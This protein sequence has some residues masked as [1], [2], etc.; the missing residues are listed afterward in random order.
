MEFVKR[1]NPDR[2]AEWNYGGAKWRLSRSKIDLFIECPRCFYVDNKLGTKR[3]GMPSFNLNIAVD[4]LFKKEF[5]VHRANGT[6]HPIMQKYKVDAV[7]FKHKQMDEWR[8]PFVGVSHLHEATDLTVCGGVDDLWQAPDG[9]LII[10]DY[11]ATSKVGRIEKLGDSPWE[12]QYQRQLGVYRWLLEKNGFEVEP[13]GYLV[14]ANASKDEDAFDDKLTFE[15]TLVT[16]PTDVEWI[17]PTLESIKKTLESDKIP[18]T[19][20]ACEYCPYREASGKKL[21]K[22]HMDNKKGNLTK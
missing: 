19:G 17:E 16:C 20:P 3:P 9:K 6:P 18:P 5:D 22:M 14:Y 4:E 13:T 1:Y 10:V 7:P 11:K 12:K 2:S 8:D 21:L 15:T